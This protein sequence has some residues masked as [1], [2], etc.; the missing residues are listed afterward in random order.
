MAVNEGFVIGG[1]DLNDDVNYNL[2]TLDLGNPAKRTE[3]A[4][5]AD[6][7]GALLVRDPLTDNRTITA[8][9][10]IPPQA[11]MALAL[12]KIAA[13]SKKLE[14]AEQQAD[15]LPILWTPANTTTK[16]LTFYALTGEVQPLALQ[17]SGADAGYFVRSPIVEIKLTCKPYGYE[18]E[19]LYPTS[20][21]SVPGTN[22]S[23]L[24]SLVL[25][26]IPGDVP[27]EARVVVTD[28]SSKDRAHAEWGLQWRNYDSLTALEVLASSFTTAGFTGVAAARTGAFN[29]AA[30][31][32][33]VIRGALVAAPSILCSTVSQFHVGTF[34]VRLRCFPTSLGVNVRLAWRD[35]D[36]ALIRNVYTDV[37]VANNWC[38]VDLGLISISPAQLGNQRW[39]GQIEAYST[40]TG[41]TLDVNALMLIPAGE[42][43]GKAR[44]IA[45]TPAVYSAK[46]TFLQATGNAT[47]KALEVGG[48][49]VGAGAATDFTV[50]STSQQL[51]RASVSDA[52]PR[53]ITASGAILTNTSVRLDALT[54]T[55]AAATLVPGVIARYVNS[56][57]YLVAYLAGTGFLNVAKFIG[58][59]QTSL[60]N[61]PLSPALT[62]GALATLQLDVSYTGAF[63]A[64]VAS[65]GNLFIASGSDAAL[66]T[67]GAL[68]AGTTGI[69]E[70]YTSAAALTRQYDNFNAWIPTDDAVIFSGQSAEFR[71]DGAIRE[72][73]TGNLYGRMQTYRGSRVLLPAAGDQNRSARIA[74]KARRYDIEVF[75][76]DQINDA[77]KIEVYYRARHQI[78]RSS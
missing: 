52:S 12:D 3:W 60:A 42:G 58:G 61:L 7:D 37:P 78:A 6:A 23:L 4:E 39:L 34:R 73:P 74:V 16:A 22:G 76:D 36:G 50:D 35:G 41:D 51:R 43:Y 29:P 45:Q 20:T 66:A 63:R 71:S 17:V 65:Q 8:R 5:G 59:V 47:G 46:D 14:E 10:A 18:P 77:I 55:N 64:A 2:E 24:P 53:L 38:D 40:G 57:N 32:N 70:N 25:A 33:P 67:A 68:A 1:L 48:S 49:W 27:A 44:A 72:D 69:Y 11:T 19:V 54:G 9:V 30:A 56:T 62:P 15:G 28:L 26:G 75:P 31:A 21:T 13:I